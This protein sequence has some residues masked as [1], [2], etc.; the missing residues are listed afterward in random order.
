M[1]TEEGMFPVTHQTQTVLP[2]HLA[3]FNVG[4]LKEKCD[5]T[6]SEICHLQELS[7]K[8]EEE[9][10][11][12]DAKLADVN[13]GHQQG[14]FDEQTRRMYV[15]QIKYEIM[16]MQLKKRSI[17]QK[18]SELHILIKTLE[19]EVNENHV[20]VTAVLTPPPT[21]QSPDCPT[22]CRSPSLTVSEHRDSKKDVQNKIK[23]GGPVS[24]PEVIDLT[25]EDDSE[26]DTYQHTAKKIGE[27]SDKSKMVNTDAVALSEDVDRLVE[28]YYAKNE[29]FLK[30]NE[31]ELPDIMENLGNTYFPSSDFDQIINKEL[32]TVIKLSLDRDVEESQRDVES[33]EKVRKEVEIQES[34]ENKN[35]QEPS[36]PT[37]VRERSHFDENNNNSKKNTSQPARSNITKQYC[38]DKE[39]KANEESSKKNNSQPS[40]A[41]DAVVRSHQKANMNEEREKKNTSQPARA[42]IT[43]QSRSDKEMKTK[44]ESSKKNQPSK[45][46]DAAI[47]SPSDQKTKPNDESSK[48]YITQTNS[49]KRLL[50]KGNKNYED[51][52]KKNI[53]APSKVLSSTNV[54]KLLQ[55]GEEP[56]S[57]VCR[58]ATNSH[59]S[60]RSAQ[61]SLDDDDFEPPR[62]KNASM[63][64]NTSSVSKQIRWSRIT[65][66]G[67]KS[68]RSTN[69]RKELDRVS[70]NSHYK[71]RKSDDRHRSLSLY[72]ANSSQ[73]A[74]PSKSTINQSE[75]AVANSSSQQKS[76]GSR[77]SSSLCR[78][79]KP[80]LKKPVMNYGQQVDIASKI[81][82]KR[83]QQKNKQINNDKRKKQHSTNLS[84]IPTITKTSLKSPLNFCSYKLGVSRA[85]TVSR[86]PLSP[87]TANSPITPPADAN[88]K[89]FE[90]NF[91]RVFEEEFSND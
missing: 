63:G 26:D 65:N 39:I 52:S 1:S 59:S 24:E 67:N 18:E 55:R 41:T 16:A 35:K 75:R 80:T 61:S 10:V 85:T 23:K 25:F 33:K 11:S 8:L 7:K 44:T 17:E 47:R 9:E 76:N 91:L 68:V 71:S 37:D 28:D 20:S 54:S 40:K 2:T 77:Q 60:V 66:D 90:R 46:T 48:K 73:S 4:T 42:N 83:R 81:L 34:T 57:K 50:P 88:D 22:S 29:Y 69:Q 72:T 64:K 36:R 86:R 82:E 14:F 74:A 49:R 5:K 70:Q 56:R 19:T 58:I 51:C 21:P 38:S 30:L 6:V 79:P 13:R 45:T 53:N 31:T 43:K 87:V 32:Q 89:N 3:F 27:S 15:S 78:P 84:V 62:R 12:L